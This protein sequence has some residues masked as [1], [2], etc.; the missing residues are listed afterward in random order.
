MFDFKS[1]EASLAS[2]LIPQNQHRLPVTSSICRFVAQILVEKLIR[3]VWVE[4]GWQN[5]LAFAILTNLVPLPLDIL[6]VFEYICIEPFE[7]FAIDGSPHL[8]LDIDIRL[9]CLSRGGEEI[10]RCALNGLHEL[11]DLIRVFGDEDIVCY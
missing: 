5:L 4:D 11:L 7:S 1:L 6:R 8:V 3:G 10:V 9:V 2:S